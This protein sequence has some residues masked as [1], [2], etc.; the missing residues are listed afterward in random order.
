[1]VEFIKQIFIEHGLL[2]PIALDS[3]DTV[4]NEVKQTA[5]FMELICQGDSL[6]D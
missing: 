6:V 4:I 2:C 3:G 5:I 1:M